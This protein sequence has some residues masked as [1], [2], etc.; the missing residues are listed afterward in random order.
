MHG[1]DAVGFVDLAEHPA[2][3]GGSEAEAGNLE[4]GF[5]EGGVVHG[6][7][8]CLQEGTLQQWGLRG[9]GIGLHFKHIPARSGLDDRF[10]QILERVD[11][12]DQRPRIDPAG[13]DHFD[14]AVEDIGEAPRADVLQLAGEQGVHRDGGA[15][16]QVPTC[17]TVAPGA[18]RRIAWSSAAATPAASKTTSKPP[19][20]S[21]A[22]SSAM[23]G[24][25][26]SSVPDAPCFSRTRG[27]R[28]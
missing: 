27:R 25:V 18:L 26:G 13:G 28:A 16:G 24:L 12:G 6:R 22:A 10:G 15:V 8:G 20:E 23:V 2:K 3:S 17:T 4:A 11:F 14:D 7:V 19:G 5:A 21:F 9:G 1:A